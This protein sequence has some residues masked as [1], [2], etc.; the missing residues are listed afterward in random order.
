VFSATVPLWD[1]NRGGIRQSEW[2]LAQ[3]SLGPDQARNTLI[4]TLADAFNRYQT[5]RRTVEIA[6]QQIRDQVRV[7]RGVYERRQQLPGQVGF[8]DVVTAQQTLSSY[9]SSYITALGLQWQAVVDV[10]NVFQSEDLYQTGQQLQAVE[11]LPDLK[12]VLP[13]RPP[14]V[15]EHDPSAPLGQAHQAAAGPLCPERPRS[16]AVASQENAAH[17]PEENR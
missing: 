17:L 6:G 9:L 13:P 2:L 4:N 14:N 7:Y 3:A 15:P 1:Q 10:A 12:N 8:G 11:P 5:G 16:A